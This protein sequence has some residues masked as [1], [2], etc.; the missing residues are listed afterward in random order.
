MPTESK[1]LYKYQFR[2]PGIFNVFEF[3][4]PWV[5]N[6]SISE[7]VR[8]FCNIRTQATYINKNTSYFKL[9]CDIE[10]QFQI[11]SVFY[12]SL[13]Q[14]LTCTSCYKLRGLQTRLHTNSLLRLVQRIIIFGFIQIQRAIL[15]S[16][17]THSKAP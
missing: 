5:V 16:Y 17:P 12:T 1:L 13:L 8:S 6:I 2:A 7:F 15:Y 9:L 4:H 3:T 14:L 11:C 10:S